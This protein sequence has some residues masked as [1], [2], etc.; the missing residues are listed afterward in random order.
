METNNTFNDYGYE[1]KLHY[2]E[3]RSDEWYFDETYYL[4][5]DNVPYIFCYVDSLSRYIPQTFGLIQESFDYFDNRKS[6]NATITE[7]I[8]NDFYREPLMI[9]FHLLTKNKFE[10]VSFTDSLDG[11]YWY[12][13]K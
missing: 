12:M 9:L 8:T 10:E 11:S 5:I 13:R 2:V 3:D 6:T 1:V 7:L 4:T